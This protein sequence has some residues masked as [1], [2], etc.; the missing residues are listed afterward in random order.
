[1]S[2][3]MQLGTMIRLHQEGW[4]SLISESILKDTRETDK[5]DPITMK[6]GGGDCW[7]LSPTGDI[8]K[9][10]ADGRIFVIQASDWHHLSEETAAMEPLE[11]STP[12]I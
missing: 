11:I 5:K 9:V 7:V 12:K 4:K 8:G 6:M 10:G 1:M 2:T 3:R